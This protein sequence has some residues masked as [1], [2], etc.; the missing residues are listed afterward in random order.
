MLINFW[1]SLAEQILLHVAYLIGLGVVVEL[2]DRMLWR[3]TPE[4]ERRP[5]RAR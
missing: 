2:L 5:G 1:I 4:A 3:L